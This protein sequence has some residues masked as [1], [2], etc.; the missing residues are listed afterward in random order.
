MK[1]QFAMDIFDVETCLSHLERIAP[2]VDIIEVGTPM[3]L[4]FGLD[5][6]TAIKKAYPKHEILSDTKIM[7]GGELEAQYAFDAGADIVVV[8]GITNIETVQAVIETAKKNSGKSYVDMM[9]IQ[10]IKSAAKKFIDLGADYVCIHNADD[11]SNIHAGLPGLKE[12]ITA[13][14]PERVAISGGIKMETIEL[15]KPYRPGILVGGA[16]ISKLNLEE[17]QPYLH[18][19][20]AKLR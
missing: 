10:D 19:M 20:L 9:C 8:M 11:V 6:V 18:Q 7:D 4:R 1:F 2:E 3:L 12:A 15:I 13:V 5:A 14:D 16:C 17:K